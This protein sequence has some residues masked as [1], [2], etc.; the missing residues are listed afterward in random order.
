MPLQMKPLLLLLLLA[1]AS[2]GHVQAT[3]WFVNYS[4]GSDA[5]SGASA[6]QA[7]QHLQTAVDRAAAGDTLRLSAG[8]HLP[9]PGNPNLA[10]LNLADL[11]LVGTSG[12][13]LN[14]N[15]LSET[16]RISADGIEL[17]GLTLA[18]ATTNLF[19]A[20]VNHLRLR[21]VSTLRNAASPPNDLGLEIVG[22]N[23]HILDTLTCTGHQRGAVLLSGGGNGLV[24]NTL[25][26]QR[27][28]EGPFTPALAILT[29][30]GAPFTGSYTNLAFQGTWRADTVGTLLSVSETNGDAVT[31]NNTAVVQTSA[32]SGALVVQFSA[33]PSF[34]TV[35]LSLAWG[36]T[37]IGE[38]ARTAGLGTPY[39][40]ANLGLQSALDYLQLRALENDTLAFA[41]LRN[42]AG[43]RWSLTP[44]Q[45][46]QI[47][48]N[49]ASNGDTIWFQFGN[50]ARAGFAETLLTLTNNSLV[51]L[52]DTLGQVTLDGR[53]RDFTCRVEGIGIELNNLEFLGA[54]AVNLLVT[55]N[56]CVG[57]NLRFTETSLVD[58][59]TAEGL[60]ISNAQNFDLENLTFTDFKTEAAVISGGSGNGRLANVS[61]QEH[62][63]YATNALVTGIRLQTTADSLSTAGDIADLSLEGALTH[64]GQGGFLFVEDTPGTLVEVSLNGSLTSPGG[65]AL[66]IR[67]G[68]GNAPGFPD[69]LDA[70]GATGLQR[71]FFPGISPNL[72]AY[73]PD[74]DAA[75]ADSFAASNQRDLRAGITRN[76]AA[77]RYGHAFNMRLSNFED[78]LTAQDTLYLYGSIIEFNAEEA[79]R[80]Q[81]PVTIESLHY[82]NLTGLY[83]SDSVRLIRE[84]YT[85]DT[86]DMTGGPLYA[87]EGRLLLN[88]STEILGVVPE[89]GNYIRGTLTFLT[90]TNSA[91]DRSFPIGTDAAYRPVTASWA[92]SAVGYI[93]LPSGPILGLANVDSLP[94]LPDSLEFC[95]GWLATWEYNAT[96]AAELVLQPALQDSVLPDSTTFA[97]LRTASGEI[98]RLPT[99]WLESNPPQARI[100]A[101]WTGTAEVF[102]AKAEVAPPPPPVITIPK[103]LSPNGDGKNDRW[104]IPQLAGLYPNNQLRIYNRFGRQVFEQDRY[105]VNGLGWDGNAT[106]GVALP[107]GVYYYVLELEPGGEVRKGSLTLLR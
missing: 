2:V 89:A 98:R 70:L 54:D 91:T 60:R 19:A 40:F 22:G 56:G 72:T 10:T 51:L 49:A 103:A 67:L 20:G 17:R 52:G 101:T 69:F 71:G 14:G 21:N 78:S 85:R 96:Q 76:R 74:L 46:P 43:T 34:S 93:N 36:A 39:A 24:L 107:D 75:L 32:L 45:R 61:I 94:T 4:S 15:G 25:H 105:L 99:E 50:Y 65:N 68:A 88:A 80:T 33:L 29:D 92:G 6:A 44:H 3:T 9:I 53:F 47:T 77:T 95:A 62:P 104:L 16:L 83:L 87:V 58:T 84:L 81:F 30:G 12:A 42:A 82:S 13:V 7:L 35:P 55:G 48:A 97:Y 64:S 38:G 102:L 63:A 1:C 18:G 57:R 26:F 27:I 106:N 23:T 79:L 90:P 66:A 41:T 8:E 28:G 37:H 100:T 86:L 59:A 31:F 11:V 5:N 73:Y